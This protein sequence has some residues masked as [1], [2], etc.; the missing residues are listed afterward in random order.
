MTTK[1]AL[2][3]SDRRVVINTERA[4]TECIFVEALG[5]DALGQ[6]QWNPRDSS[7]HD[8]LE[9]RDVLAI[10]RYVRPSLDTELSAPNVLG[11]ELGRTTLD[12]N[13]WRVVV[14]YY[15][16]DDARGYSLVTE[17][18]RTDACG[19]ERWCHVN[20]S[21]LD[22]GSDLDPGRRDCDVLLACLASSLGL[23]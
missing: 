15:H 8:R 3:T 20:T 17:Q 18:A 1:I 19:G 22:Y 7:Q 9:A 6:P 2:Q 11:V 12:G 5:H 23:V 14:T 4:P 13:I 16:H 10:V 21:P